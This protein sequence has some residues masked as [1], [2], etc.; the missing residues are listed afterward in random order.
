MEDDEMTDSND[1]MTDLLANSLEGNALGV[2]D[3]VNAMMNARALDALQSM[4]VDVAKSIYGTYAS[5]EEG[6]EGTEAEIEDMEIPQDDD[7]FIDSNAD[8]LFAELDQLA[9]SEEEDFEQDE[10]DTND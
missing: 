9:D 6:G 8:D 4:K 10:D 1:F 3:A 2:K 5:D 7:E